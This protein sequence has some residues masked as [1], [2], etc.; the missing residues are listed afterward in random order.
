MTDAAISLSPSL[1]ADVFPFHLALN[2]AGTIVQVGRV[3]QRIC[4][5]LEVGGN[6]EQYFQIQRP[7]IPLNF[8]AIQAH[9]AALFILEVR[10]S[11]LLL[12][13]Q[14]VYIAEQETLLFLGSPWI[15]DL[16]ALAGSGLTL[17][18]FAIHDPIADYLVLL[19]TQKTALA[20]ARK[21]AEKLKQQRTEVSKA[22]EREKELNELKSRFITTTSH[23]FRTPLGII[24]SSTGIMQDYADKIDG[25]MRQKHLSRI[26]AAVSRIT[27]LLDDV[28][29]MNRVES[30]LMEA[31]PQEFQLANLC[32]E[33]VEGLR[34]NTTHQFTITIAPD[35]S[36]RWVVLD[37]ALCHQLLTNLLSNAVK[38]TPEPGQIGLTMTR[39]D[40]QI[41]LV[42]QD[43]GIGIPAAD[44]TAVFQPFHRASNVGTIAG[45]GLGLAIAKHCVD[46]HQG[47]ITIASEVGVGTAIT[48]TLPLQSSFDGAEGH[49]EPVGS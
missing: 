41:L 16:S 14:M 34:T 45:T 17:T 18:D 13:G 32:Y 42:I 12:K 1:L 11:S 36:N 20:D 24:A 37:Q 39:Q 26:Q 15:S 7:A 38:Y 22:L 3:L 33:V 48:V 8:Q 6:F 35:L 28:L 9:T 49:G 43:S 29:T 25:R 47:E 31:N 21:L 44:L 27:A 46:L 19:Q 4:P 2:Q 5:A 30:G 40:N 10:S 23:E